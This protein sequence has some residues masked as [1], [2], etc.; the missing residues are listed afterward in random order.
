M[1][2][3][4]GMTTACTSS[5]PSATR[6]FGPSFASAL[7]QNR[8]C[9]VTSARYLL[10]IKT[11]ECAGGLARRTARAVALPL[12]SIQCTEPSCVSPTTGCVHTADAVCLGACVGSGPSERVWHLGVS[13]SLCHLGKVQFQTG[14]VG[15]NR[16]GRAAGGGE[17]QGV[18]HALADEVARA[19]CVCWMGPVTRWW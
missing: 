15:A 9:F 19:A 5:Q 10:R 1:V 7:V 2:F 14:R 11:K 4:A 16:R 3:P 6:S 17:A 12:R 8:F 18:E 13:F